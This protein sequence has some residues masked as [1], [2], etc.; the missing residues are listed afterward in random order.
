MQMLVRSTERAA[1]PPINVPSEVGPDAAWV[2]REQ[3]RI[4]KKVFAACHRRV[5]S[6]S[7][8][9]QEFAPH[10]RLHIS[11]REGSSEQPGSRKE[12][13]LREDEF[14][15]VEPECALSGNLVWEFGD[16]LV[17]EYEIGRFA[18]A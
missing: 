7:N 3:P 2:F 12:I 6:R 10:E 15:L 14:R 5:V 13:L 1:A 11:G 18:A 8:P 17:I 9:A 16:Q 4:E